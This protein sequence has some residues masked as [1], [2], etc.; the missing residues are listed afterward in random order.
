MNKNV[1]G[2]TRRINRVVL[3]VCT[4]LSLCQ[5]TKHRR[6]R[7]NSGQKCSFHAPM[8]AEIAFSRYICSLAFKDVFFF[9]SFEHELI[10]RSPRL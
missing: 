5:L 2:E 1:P 8:R 6:A 4:V 10:A 9:Q 3:E 7:S